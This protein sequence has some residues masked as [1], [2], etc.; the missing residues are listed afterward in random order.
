MTEPSNTEDPLLKALPP[1]SDYLTYLTIIEY[2]LTK[3]R[4]PLLHDVLQDEALTTNIGWDLVHVL[5]PFLPEA[6]LCLEDVAR[7]GNPRE[8]ILKV[9]ELLEGMVREDDEDE[10]GDSGSD[11][12]D[13]EGGLSSRDDLS[14]RPQTNRASSR[15]DNLI[16][17]LKMLETLHRRIKTKYPSRF[18]STS[19]NATI[20]AYSPL[21]SDVEVTSNLINFANTML[22]TTKPALPPRNGSAPQE[23]ETDVSS[24]IAPDPE[25]EKE[26]LSVEESQKQKQLL[27]AFL[28]QVLKAYG[29]ASSADY[30]DGGFAWSTRFQEILHPEKRIPGRSTQ[31]ERF[32]QDEALATKERTLYHLHDTIMACGMPRGKA[33]NFVLGV[34]LSIPRISSHADGEP[35]APPPSLPMIGSLLFYCISLAKQRFHDNQPLNLGIS[36]FPDFAS[37]VSHFLGSHHSDPNTTDI[38]ISSVSSPMIIDALLFLGSTIFETGSEAG[39]PLNYPQVYEP[40]HNLLQNLSLVSLNCP[41]PSLRYNAHILTSQILH[42]HSDEKVRLRFIV[43]TLEDC[44]FENLKGSAV[45]WLKEEVMRVDRIQQS[46]GEGGGKDAP[47][48]EKSIFLDGDLFKSSGAKLALLPILPLEFTATDPTISVKQRV[49][50][51]LPLSNYILASLNFWIFLLANK[52]LRQRYRVVEIAEDHAFEERWLASFKR[53]MVEGN[54]NK[55]TEED[56]GAVENTEDE[57]ENSGKYDRA[58]EHERLDDDDVVSSIR[59]LGTV[60]TMVSER[61]SAVR[62]TEQ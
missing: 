39:P 7:L 5:L 54:P 44:P 50:A 58:G 60:A 26:T 8:V 62:A 34:I 15:K 33:L 17:L 10:G 49:E 32:S 41:L 13:N 22:A 47:E 12:A 20:R 3:E 19:L 43:D 11:E 48:E 61:L 52:A 38:D 45:G 29:L 42:T 35:G 14:T 31:L 16:M 40:F 23:R 51:L 46:Q 59:L 37:L 6:E 4:L 1:A 18:L 36:L 30:E 24:H 27:Q 25:D 53:L 21:A 56:S 57:R 28:L 2:N 9:T 55:C